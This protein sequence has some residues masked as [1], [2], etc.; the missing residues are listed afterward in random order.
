MRTSGQTASATAPSPNCPCLPAC[1]PRPLRQ[2]YPEPPLLP[3]DAAQAAKA[4]LFVE[5]FSSQFTGGVFGL[6]RADTPEAVEAGKQKFVAALKV[7]RRMANAHTS[8]SC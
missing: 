4:R 5:T 6:L 7:R 3:A 1:L 2:A 8:A